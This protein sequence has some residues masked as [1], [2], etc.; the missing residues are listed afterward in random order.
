MVYWYLASF[1]TM[2]YLVNA[3]YIP[4]EAAVIRGVQ[5][6]Q[7]QRDLSKI[8]YKLTFRHFRVPY[9]ALQVLQSIES[10]ENKFYLVWNLIE[11]FLMRNVK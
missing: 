6:S 3:Q 2:Q 8:Q 1:C 9:F 10:M 7:D 5:A 4:G 11:L